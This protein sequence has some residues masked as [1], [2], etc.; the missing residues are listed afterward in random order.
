MVLR[1]CFDPC[2]APS[3]PIHP[4]DANGTFSCDMA[5]RT[6]PWVT[7]VW[8]SW[9]IGWI[10]VPFWRLWVPILINWDQMPIDLSAH[11][12]W[13]HEDKHTNIKPTRLNY[14]TPVL[15]LNTIQINKFYRYI[16]LYIYTKYKTN[17]Y[18]IE[19]MV[20]G[21][22]QPSDDT[23]VMVPRRCD[24]GDGAQVMAPGWW[25]MASWASQ[26]IRWECSY[27]NDPLLH[28]AP[29]RCGHRIEAIRLLE[30]LDL[31]S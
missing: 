28:G 17:G 12:P 30:S 15:T 18:M 3:P 19:L 5:L 6:Y 16:Y 8:F 22:W 13:T 31:H 2:A 14:G 21:W 11:L 23:Q 4:A 26:P 20:P 10:S 27:R 7:K 1:P 9:Y 24:P 25:P 29:N